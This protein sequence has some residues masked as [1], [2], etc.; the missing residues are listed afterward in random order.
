VTRR[1]GATVLQATA[2]ARD[3]VDSGT[4]GEPLALAVITGTG[5]CYVRAVGV[6]VIPMGARAP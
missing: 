1:M 4:A 2:G 5:Y 3:R 6:A